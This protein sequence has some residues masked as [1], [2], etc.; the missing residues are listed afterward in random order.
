MQGWIADWEASFKAACESPGVDDRIHPA[1]LNY[2][3]KSIKVM[4]E[5]E[6]PS[7]ALWPLIQTWTLA[8]ERLGE[9]HV[10]FWRGA[11]ADLG[12]SGPGFADRVQGLDQYIDGIEILLDELA[13][14]NGL[15]T[16][17]KL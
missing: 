6:V 4:L 7:A 5:G 9:D 13:A 2:Y 3:A 10:K 8:V 11:L 17:S 12:W 16:S 1:R 14:A 15:E